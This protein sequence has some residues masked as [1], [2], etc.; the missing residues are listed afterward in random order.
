MNAQDVNALATDGTLFGPDKIFTYLFLTIG[1]TKALGPFA[2]MTAGAAPSARRSLALKG[3]AIATL[4]LVATGFVGQST[5]KS[6]GVS[7]PA[8]IVAG[9]IILF[10]V[11]IRSVLDVYS[12]PAP[13]TTPRPALTT[14]LALQPLAFPTIV[15]P[16]GIAVVILLLSIEP[17]QTLTIVGI[18]VLMMVLN[19][20]AMLFARPIL[21]IL[22]LPLQLVANV[23]TVLQVAL[24]IEM[25]IFAFRLGL[26]AFYSSH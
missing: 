14:A 4:G 26:P 8:L 1:P 13:S 19:L 16:Y 21:R 22:G 17:T 12:D 11:A 20:A 25:I 10:L 5:V 2:K 6:W 3:V 15:P 23:L 18:L 9:G 24:A 7:L